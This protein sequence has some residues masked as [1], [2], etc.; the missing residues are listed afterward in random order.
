M[1]RI[2]CN[3][4]GV[5]STGRLAAGGDWEAQ[6]RIGIAVF[7]SV[8]VLSGVPAGAQ[9]PPPPLPQKAKARL[10]RMIGT[11]ESRWDYLDKE[12]NVR[13]SVAGTETMR[14]LVEG[15]VIGMSTRVPETGSYNESLVYFNV[16]EDRLYLVSVD[17][18]GQLWKL[19]GE[20]DGHVL[21]AEP[22][23]LPD[24]REMMIRFTENE[25]GP[26]FSRGRDGAQLGRGR[27]MEARVRPT[28][29]PRRPLAGP[30]GPLDGLWLRQWLP[31][32]SSCRAQHLLRARPERTS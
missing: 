21:A 12:G 20:A 8:L 9:A 25:T 14:Y 31:L 26:R 30:R 2:K 16:K 23:K 28:D 13:R 10:E 32:D 4:P 15:R 7:V 1:P 19:T 17:P 11:W 3:E 18:S 24:G 27:D 6:L 22:V 29:A 5:S